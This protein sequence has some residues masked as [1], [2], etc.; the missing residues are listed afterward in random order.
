MTHPTP[1]AAAS[2]AA[3]AQA[4]RAVG[5]RTGDTEESINDQPYEVGYDTGWNACLYAINQK[6][7]TQ[8]AQQGGGEAVTVGA[9]VVPEL[10]DALADIADTVRRTPGIGAEGY[11]ANGHSEAVEIANNAIDKY[12]NCVTDGWTLREVS[13]LRDRLVS[14]GISKFLAG[15]S[16]KDSDRKFT[17]GAVTE[18]WQLC[19]SLLTPDLAS[20]AD[21]G[22]S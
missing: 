1:P 2:D 16:R 17:H 6:A 3:I 9:H 18:A 21:G 11:D 4:F 15:E 8:S 5:E 7:R 22:K 10:L 13:D 14:A 20:K 12:Q 19:E